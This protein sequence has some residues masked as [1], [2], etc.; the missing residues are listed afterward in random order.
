MDETFLS[1]KDLVQI[2]NALMPAYPDPQRMVRVLREDEEIL[3]GMLSDERL[4]RF[5]TDDPESLLQVS[6]RLFFTVLLNRVRQELESRAYTL[7]RGE[8]H[9]MI[10]FDSGEV[11]R[12]LKN[13][14]LRNYLAVMLSSFVRINS[15]SV[16]FRVKKG[17]WRRFR[18][19]DFDVDSLIRYSRMVQ[20]E[21]QFHAYRRIADVCLFIA[22]FFADAIDPRNLTAE[23]LR[24][25][26]LAQGNWEKYTQQGEYYYR[27]ASRHRVAQL[28]ELDDVL[29]D[30]SDKFIL[31][32]KP[33][34]FMANHYLAPFKQKLFPSDIPE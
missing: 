28:R 21:E 26:A 25:D 1:E 22:G 9:L 8:R 18:F 13:R 12:L 15:Y 29:Q 10:V 19:S 33:L 14:R 6:P 4:F 2:V 27:E 24:L 7:E 30:L 3:E 20:N 34:S 16:T 31:A 5:L 11:V 17:I 23:G 32:T